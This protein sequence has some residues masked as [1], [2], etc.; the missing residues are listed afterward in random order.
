MDGISSLRLSD[1]GMMGNLVSDSATVRQRLDQL[2]EQVSTGRVADSYAGLGSGAAVSLDLNPDIDRLKTWQAN[3]NA[4]TG[5]L[6]VTQSAMTQ[7]Q[8]IA[9]DLFAQLNNLPGTL[10]SEVDGIAASARDA[11]ARRQSARYDRRRYVC[12]RRSGYGEPADTDPTAS[13]ALG[14]IPRSRRRWA[15][16]AR[17]VLRPRRRPRWASPDPMRRERARFRRI[18]RNRSRRSGRGCSKWRSGTA[19]RYS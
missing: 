11:L 10:G 6:D 16:L 14:F 3:I 15:I 2:T 18:C 5:R 9:S 8:Q 12:V 19:I 4:A 7:I 13:P 1:Y 17:P